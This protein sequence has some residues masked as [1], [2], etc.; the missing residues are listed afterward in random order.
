M[1][2]V[3]YSDFEFSHDA[4]ISGKWSN[5]SN[6]RFHLDIIYDCCHVNIDLNILCCK[7][8]PRYLVFSCPIG[9]EKTKNDK[10]AFDK[11]INT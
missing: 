1:N 11:L 6:V 9:Q 4:G 3:N 8:S 5:F 7:V 2:Q 10:L